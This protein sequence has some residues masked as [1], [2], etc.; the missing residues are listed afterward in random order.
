MAGVIS[1][2]TGTR[3]EPIDSYV[4]IAGT[5]ATFKTIFTSNGMPVALD[6]GSVPYARILNPRF[7]SQ[8]GSP[9]PEV[10]AVCNGT[11]VPGQQYEYQFT[12]NVPNNQ[13]PIDDYIISYYATLGGINNNFGDEFFCITA[14]PGMLGLKRSAYATVD[15]VRKKKFNI[16]DYLPKIYANDV[17]A[18][19]SLILDHLQDATSR[20]REELNLEGQRG[21]TE[22]YRLF[23]IYYTIYTLLL[24]ARG[25][26]GSSVSDQ[27]IMFWRGESDRI[28]AQEKRKHGTFQGLPLGR[29]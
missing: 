10:L 27:N 11:L 6:T 21:M 14:G 25:E 24:A 9:V 18:R 26:D 3:I 29:G 22:N 16:D 1:P 15:D 17:N 2:V 4:F 7:L 23:C 13:V 5:T 8:A 12:W 20:L 19:N 28:L